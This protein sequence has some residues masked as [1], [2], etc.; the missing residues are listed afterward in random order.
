M[1]IMEPYVGENV[2]ESCRRAYFELMKNDEPI[3]LYF[4]DTTI[5]FTRDNEGLHH[6]DGN[7]DLVELERVWG[8][9]NKELYDSL[10]RTK[11]KGEEE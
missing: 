4:N 7:I 2:A 1:R 11:I 10:H 9:S 3:I 5:M 6:K 8:M